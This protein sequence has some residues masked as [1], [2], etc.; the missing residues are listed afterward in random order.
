M[1]KKNPGSDPVKY[2]LKDTELKSIYDKYLEWWDKNNQN[3]FD[4]FKSTNP[5]DGLKIFWY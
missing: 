3:K 5:L 2:R 4:E 1:L